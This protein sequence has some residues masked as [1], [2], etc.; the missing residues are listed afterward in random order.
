MWRLL[1]PF[2]EKL[3]TRLERLYGD[4][5]TDRLLER[6]SLI[7]GRYN[8][9]AE[10]CSN[11][12]PCWDEKS[13]LLI[14]YGDMITT[15]REVPLKTLRRFLNDYLAE[16]FSGVHLLP[17][18]PYSSDDGF[19]IID[20]RKVDKRLGSWDDISLLAEDFHLMVD[21]VLNHV[22]RRS[23]WFRDY[24]GGIAP[25]RHYF[26]EIEQEQDLSSVVRPRTTPL[27]TPV[28]TTHGH[29]FVWTTFSSD[30]VDL[31]YANPDV[32][33]EMI[34]ILFTYISRGATIIRLD[35]I[36]YLLKETGSPCINL[37]QTH[38]IVKL[39]RNMTDNVTPG[40][41]LLTET[42][43][44][45]E[46]NISYFGAGDEAHL[47]YQFSLPPLILQ[48]IHGGS[49]RHLQKWAQ[50]LHPPIEGCN[51][52]N[53]TA[54][55]DGIGVR[56]LEGLLDEKEIEDLTT[57]I[58]NCGGLIN[59]RRDKSGKELPYEYNITFFDA[60]KD[61]DRPDDTDIQLLRFLCSQ[62]IML[63]LQGIPA[64]YFH[65]LTGSTNDYDGVTRSGGNRAI[66][67]RRWRD[68]ELRALI[69]DPET[70]TARLFF[71]YRDLLAKRAQYPAFHP[72]TP[73]K[74]IETADSLFVVTRTPR[75]N[76]PV[77]CLH[78]VTGIKQQIMLSD[79][80]SALSDRRNTRDIISNKDMGK[81]IHLN[82][83]QC[84]WLS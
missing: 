83:Y 44:P 62:I 50:E 23:H 35:A 72:D 60:M 65:S 15:D 39:L 80:G 11:E 56:P 28:S 13:C 43:L 38:E 1:K 46:E 48:T 22:S 82:P 68:K 36:G 73:Q 20:Y 27:L 84:C 42:N 47:V 17:F 53:F 61:L 41:V 5:R 81:T 59:Y 24:I 14:T 75:E 45:H 71:N 6:L 2:K 34:D 3:R 52:I 31:N 58:L 25:A 19:S 78:N 79:L 70:T 7:A 33:L 30:Q 69:E 49:S 77:T 57:T 37:P 54:S 26:I 12:S 67:R 74:I 16:T 66:N 29:H 55:H 10:N 4:D 8:Y 9:L 51:F 21:L 64:I 63:S 18:F 32:L 40:I 76:S